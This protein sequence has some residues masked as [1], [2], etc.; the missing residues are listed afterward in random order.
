MRVPVHQVHGK[1]K[2]KEDTVE[3]I[4][5]IA[6]AKHYKV[7]RQKAFDYVDGAG[8]K[9][10]LIVDITLPEQSLMVEVQKKQDNKSIIAEM[11]REKVARTNNWI[12]CRVTEN[13]VR[14]DIDTALYKVRRELL[15]AG[16]K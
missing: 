12:V 4:L 3:D 8:Q 16:K 9:Q 2:P 13:E 10:V 1:V 11:A 6:L 15:R 7:L 14:Y 5:A